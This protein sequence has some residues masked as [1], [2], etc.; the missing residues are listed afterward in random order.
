MGGE[1]NRQRTR[2]RPGKIITQV[3]VFLLLGAIVNVAVAWGCAR[4]AVLT[5]SVRFH[6]SHQALAS[7]LWRIHAKGRLDG[8]ALA[9]VQWRG[10]GLRLSS[11]SAPTES[12][13]QSS[14]AEVE[15]DWIEVLSAG[16]PFQSMSGYGIPGLLPP[17]RLSHLLPIPGRLQ[18][19]E[20]GRI[21]IERML[22]L[23]PLWPGFAVNTL[24]YATI[25]WLLIPGPFV[26]RRVIRVKRGRCPKCGY[27]L[28]GAP[29]EVGP[30]GG[31][32]E[33]GWNRGVEA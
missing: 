7:R 8:D 21:T 30:G 32:P 29:P 24:F 10:L 23:R 6:D 5:H 33:C 9:G 2:L 16:L 13:E 20:S 11:I 3:I 27:D 26:L 17:S 4:W 28:R 19:D 15:P 22:P 25:L 1:R 14:S 31:C 12:E 18:L